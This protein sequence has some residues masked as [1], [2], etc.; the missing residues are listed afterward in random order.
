MV[1]IVTGGVKV[2][3]DGTIS[4]DTLKF[5]NEWQAVSEEQE[6]TEKRETEKSESRQVNRDIVSEPDI[7]AVNTLGKWFAIVSICAVIILFVAARMAKRL[8][9]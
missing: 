1:G 6:K 3:P 5:T 8:G 2:L 7:K 9:F 4:G